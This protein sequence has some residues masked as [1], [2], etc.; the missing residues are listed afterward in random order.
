MANYS[1]IPGA[2][3]DQ[4]MQGLTNRYNDVTS[5]FEDPAAAMRR[6]AGL[7][8]EDDTQANVKPVTQ[9]VKTDPTTGD[10]TMTISG[11]PEDLSASNPLTPTVMPA[12]A[13]VAAPVTAPVAPGQ[14]TQP[15][16]QP[17]VFRPQAVAPT[18][19]D[20][21]N[22]SLLPENQPS[23]AAPVAP[24][25]M[26]PVKYSNPVMQQDVN[27]LKQNY[28]Q[29]TGQPLPVTSEER[30]RAKQTQLY[31]DWAAGKPNVYQPTNPANF[32]GQAT[33]HGNAID[34]SS[35]ADP[36]AL[37]AAGWY[38]P[39]P[40]GD[41]VHWERNPQ[42]QPGP[43]VKV[44]DTGPVTS[45][46]INLGSHANELNAAA[47]DGNIKALGAGMAN[48]TNPP[49]QKAYA[50]QTADLLER[51]KNEKA[52]EKT[53]S[54]AVA[55]GNM[56]PLM[57]EIKKSTE[58]G[59]YVKAYLFQ[60]LGLNDLAK[61][62]QQKLGA[63]KRW[64]AAVGPNGEQAIV[65]YDGQGLP[66]KGFNAAG[67]EIS[68]KQLSTFAAGA[69]PTKSHLMPSVHGSPVQNAQG[70]T[71]L[72]IYD[73]RQRTS[74]VQVGNERRPTTG[75]TTMAQ[76]PIA[77]YNASGAKQQGVQ[78][79]EG[80]QNTPLPA[81]PGRGP[82]APGQIQPGA[83]TQPQMQP[84]PGAQVQPQPA[85]TSGALPGTTPPQALATPAPTVGG[86]AGQ[87]QGMA[88]RAAE[89]K[90]YV[91]K[92]M[93]ELQVKGDQAGEVS[94]V[95]KDQ[96]GLLTRNPELA[97]LLNGQGGT[98]DK[99]RNLLR[100]TVTAGYSDPAELSRRIAEL[101][102]SQTQSNALYEY[103]GLQ[104][105]ILPLTLKANAGAGSISEAEHKINR[106]ANV[107]M[108][109]VPMY[110]AFSL[111]TRDQFD[112]NVNSYERDWAAASGIQSRTQHGSAWSAEKKK[113]VDAYDNIYRARAEYISKYGN[114]PSAVVDAYKYYPAPEYNAS[115][116]T[117][118][119]GGYS[120]KAARPSLKQFER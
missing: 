92:F 7:P 32:P 116:K 38:R 21:A 93:P 76:N 84:Q 56:L 37:E 77:V 8:A 70:E 89:S 40:E 36:K 99:V 110:S 86:V 55:S 96:I 102:L 88:V 87:K 69:L 68:Q 73:P 104:N 97:G 26:Q 44:A 75:W 54:E 29:T 90:D 117:W 19:N 91:E 71:G 78:A 100:D 83:P 31:N 12:A 17:A 111:L 47:K 85:P 105:K 20:Y 59:S 80:Y 18:W 15:Q 57:K 3:W 52:A 4:R 67:E 30:D 119:Y 114:T 43:G 82:V 28:E 118:E 23:P 42:S 64:E 107:D 1:D 72:M 27:T 61:E 66:L 65:Q 95:R 35:T 25:A 16:M 109:R 63:G 51:Q 13:P 115:S 14:P 41:P 103:I 101:N 39:N 98:G 46:Q 5:M 112:K 53:V 48:D 60:R 11:R 2:M 10:Q 113:L 9:T 106:E 50:A 62:E 58:E 81:M 49:V 120:A 24:T 94:R 108:T 34:V 79:A 74:Y 45:E 33:F 22:P 6:R